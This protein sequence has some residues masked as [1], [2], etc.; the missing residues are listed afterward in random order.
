[1]MKEDPG[2]I[3]EVQYSTDSSRLNVYANRFIFIACSSYSFQTAI[4]ESFEEGTAAA[5][6]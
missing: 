5:C 3:T 6:G 4:I 2:D 1:M